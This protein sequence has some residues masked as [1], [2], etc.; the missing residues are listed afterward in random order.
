MSKQILPETKITR[1]KRSPDPNIALSQ[2][3][4][5][6]NR[7]TYRG[8]WVVLKGDQLLA[9]ASSSEELLKKIDPT[10]GKG[11]LITVIY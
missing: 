9:D 5:K 1:V 11:K 8:R 10:D 6:A 7:E 2:N 4:I 3:W